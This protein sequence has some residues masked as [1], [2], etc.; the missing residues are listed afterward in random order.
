M[1]DEVVGQLWKLIIPGYRN[2]RGT[3]SYERY[4]LIRKLVTERAA[5]ACA[6]LCEQ[7]RWRNPTLPLRPCDDRDLHLVSA[8]NRYG[9]DP[10]SWALAEGVTEYPFDG[11]QS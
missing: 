1:N 4:W 9:I 7:D 10:E 5:A 3:A 8:L 2:V 11:E 6:I